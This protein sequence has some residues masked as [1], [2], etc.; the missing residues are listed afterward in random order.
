MHRASELFCAQNTTVTVS[1]VVIVAAAVGLI[2]KRMLFRHPE[3]C[4]SPIRVRRAR[5]T[6]IG[7]TRL[8][9]SGVIPCADYDGVIHIVLHYPKL[10][11]LKRLMRVFCDYLIPHRNFHCVPFQ[12]TDGGPIQWINVKVDVEQHFFVH[13]GLR[14]DRR[15]LSALQDSNIQDVIDKIVGS[16]LKTKAEGRPWWEVHLF[17][18][19][20]AGNTCGGDGLVLIRVHHALGDGISL[21]EA[22]SDALTDGQGAPLLEVSKLFSPARA[23]DGRK[24]RPGLLPAVKKALSTVACFVRILGLATVGADTLCAY[25]DPSRGLPFRNQRFTVYLQSHSLALVKNIKD[26]LSEKTKTRITVNDVEFAIFAGAVRR[27][28]ARHGNDVGALSLRA[29]TPFAVPEAVDPVTKYETLLRNHWTF[30]CNRLPVTAR[31]AVERIID[32]HRSWSALKNSPMVPVCFFIHRISSLLPRGMQA[33]TSNDI[34]TRVSTVFSNVPGPGCPIYFGGEEVESAHMLYANLSH[35]VGLISINGVVHISLVMI[36]ENS[37]DSP[38]N[39]K[40]IRRQLTECFVE[41]LVEA[42]EQSCGCGRMDVLKQLKLY[43]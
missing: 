2:A 22:L 27:F 30:V 23:S 26:A 21:M 4:P 1:A 6:S 12:R 41:E 10:P 36:T 3:A 32:S 43:H 20:A 28:C 8:M 18:S 5:N 42:A 31:S 13:H 35:Q 14:R 9:A 38:Q 15:A 17:S 39:R 11:E 24:Y 25:Q 7:S 34:M 16:R 40:E 33:K 19:D 37:S 29:L